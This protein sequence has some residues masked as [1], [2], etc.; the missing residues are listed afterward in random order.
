VPRYLAAALLTFL[1]ADLACAAQR[2]RRLATQVYTLKTQTGQVSIPM[3]VSLSWGTVHPGINRAVIVFH[4]KDRNV[5]SYY[6]ALQIAAARPAASHALLLAPQF[7]Q[8][9]D[10]RTHHLAARFLRW[11]QG[12]W[13]TGADATGPQ[14]LSAFDVI[15][16][17]LRD[18]GNR[19]LFP[20]L[21]T[22]VLVG[23]SAGGQLLNR[24]AIVGIEPAL[25][26][27]AGIHLRFVIANPGSY[28]YFSDERPRADGSLAPFPATSCPGFDHW[29]YG[30]IDPPRY[31]AD[32][33]PED[34]ARRQ[35][36]YLD[37]DVIY[38]LGAQDV[39]PVDSD[40]DISCAGEAQ[41][42]DRLDRGRAYF[43]YLQGRSEGIRQRLFLVP[44]LAH[45]GNRMIESPCSVVALFDQ[46][47]CQTEVPRTGE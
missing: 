1:L 5:E 27:A 32:R 14:P 39:D 10:A 46:G 36:L 29:R 21:D 3:E 15:D 13:M 25:L 38:L 44:R 4:G 43:R 24:Y 37:S 35:T 23:H 20:D 2:Q 11:H 42:K 33:T 30:P 40:L 22:I 19:Q 18:L 45:V 17:L 26:S 6:K 16:A 7:L 47:T 28:F 12:S 34:W 41:G 8:E 31:V 9:E